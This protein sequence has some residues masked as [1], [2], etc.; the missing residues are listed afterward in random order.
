M[1]E[2]NYKSLSAKMFMA[3][4]QN[5]MGRNVL[6]ILISV[7]AF[8]FSSQAQENIQVGGVT[9]SMIVYA[10]SGLAQ[11]RPLVISLH[12]AGQGADYQRNQA[13]WESCADTAKFVVVYPTA[14]NLRWDIGGT[15][16]INFINAII[17]SMSTRY[18]INKNRV[19]VTGFSMGGMMSYHVANNMANKVAAIGPVSGYL[20]SNV[21]NSARPMPIIHVHGTADDVVF[22]NASGNQQGVAAMLQKWRTW[23]KCTSSSVKTDPY[24]SN[25]PNSCAAMEY[26]GTCDKSAVALLSI[27]G[28][29]H[30]HSNDANCVISTLEIWNF[31][32]KYSLGTVT[33]D[34]EESADIKTTQV[35]PNPFTSEGLHIKSVGD[36]HY[37]IIDM[38]GVLVEEGNANSDKAV[39]AMLDQGLYMLSVEND[40]GITIHKILKR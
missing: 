38:K 6:F 27:E 14:I 37:R 5:R 36:F 10:P 40:K 15:S 7:C 13:K 9:R 32:K 31:M 39:G 12:G 23:N 22:Y 30:W 26:W 20:F 24:P 3:L 21:A 34:L 35:S 2:T 16:D 1:I 8:S 19:Y 33:T 4:I 17:E 18:K 29:G 28:K 11:N 25:K